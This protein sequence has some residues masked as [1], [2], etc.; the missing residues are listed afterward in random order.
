VDETVAGQGARNPGPSG[1]APRPSD[2]RRPQPADSGQVTDQ[3][4]A[5]KLA[6]QHG[7]D[8]MGEPTFADGT[9]YG[10]DAILPFF[11]EQ[12]A[13]RV[14]GDSAAVPDVVFRAGV[15]DTFVAD[16]FDRYLRGFDP[17]QG[18]IQVSAEVLREIHDSRPSIAR[19]LAEQL[20]EGRLLADA[21]LPDPKDPARAWLVF[22]PTEGRSRQRGPTVVEV[23]ADPHGVKV[24]SARILRSAEPVERARAL[25]ERMDADRPGGALRPLRRVQAQQPA[26]GAE[27]SPPGSETNPTGSGMQAAAPGMRVRVDADHAATMGAARAAVAT[28]PELR[29]PTGE[30]DADG[31]AITLSGSEWLAAGEADVAQAGREA[32]GIQAAADCFLRSAA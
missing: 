28:L 15:A 12:I 29:V 30:V 1:D 26:A 22:E 24:L 8:D 5:A 10:R 17:A 6:R 4:F 16:G 23:G 27:P 14:K 13:S 11:D 7:V 20:H 9:A 31:N 32:L 21:V 25:A 18:D 19:D 2:G 3:H